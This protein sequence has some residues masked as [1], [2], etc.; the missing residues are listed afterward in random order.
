MYE[1]D[2]AFPPRV[3]D[4]MIEILAREN[5]EFLNDQLSR[6]SA[7]ERLHET[8]RLMHKDIHKH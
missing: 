3:I 7:E 4:H 5:D 2:G 6:M 1:V 8:R